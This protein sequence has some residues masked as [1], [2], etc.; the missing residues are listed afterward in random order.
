MASQTE[1]VSPIAGFSHL[2]TLPDIEIIDDTPPQ[3]A[4]K[5]IHD[6]KIF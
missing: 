3:T 1:P 4:K 2:I 6:N 5:N